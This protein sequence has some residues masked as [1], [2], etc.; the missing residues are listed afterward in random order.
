MGDREICEGL[1]LPNMNISFISVYPIILQVI[2]FKNA[3]Q[4]SVA[5]SRYFFLQQIDCNM[6]L[7]FIF[8]N[9]CQLKITL[10]QEKHFQ[11]FWTVSSFIVTTVFNEVKIVLFEILEL[12]V[13]TTYNLKFQIM[14][15]F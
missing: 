11:N 7:I 9:L 4:C 8:T 1:L 15:Y 10:Y 12:K 13:I 3:W 6:V 14:F 2:F 5:F